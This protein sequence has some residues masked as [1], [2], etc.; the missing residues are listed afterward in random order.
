MFHARAPQRGISSSQNAIASKAAGE[1]E[2]SASS[3]MRISSSRP[4]FKLTSSVNQARKAN[5][6]AIPVLLWFRQ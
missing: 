2:M 6:A 3:Q 4:E 5:I 1:M